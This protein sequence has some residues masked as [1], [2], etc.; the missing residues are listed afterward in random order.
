MKILLDTHVWIW[1]LAGSEKLN[2]KLRT[3]LDSE[4]NEIWLSP[5]S[6]WET[7][8]LGEK[9][10]L[11]LQPDPISWVREALAQCSFREAALNTEVAIKSRQIK[12]PHQDPADRFLAATAMIYQLTLATQD[13]DLKRIPGLDILD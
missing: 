4:D 12:L 10:R 5:I 13:K 3:A 7:L 8:V 2:P 6:I 1:L 11:K 9:K